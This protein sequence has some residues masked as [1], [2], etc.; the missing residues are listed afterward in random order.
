M[1]YAPAPCTLPCNSGDSTSRKCLAP[2]HPTRRLSLPSSH[3]TNVGTGAPGGGAR[4]RSCLGCVM[5]IIPA[6]TPPPPPHA[7]PVVNLSVSLVIYLLMHLFGGHWLHAPWR[8]APCAAPPL[9]C[10]SPLPYPFLR[11]SPIGYPS[12]DTSDLTALIYL[13]CL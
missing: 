2:C 1:S 13:R 5:G 3:L 11:P 8:L 9:H 7:F 4:C 6:G 12:W 10:R